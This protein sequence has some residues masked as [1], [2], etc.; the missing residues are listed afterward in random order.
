MKDNP[1]VDAVRKTRKQL[2]AKYE[3]DLRKLVVHYQQM[4]RQYEGNIYSHKVMRKAV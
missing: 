2:S 1:I 4:E 3:N